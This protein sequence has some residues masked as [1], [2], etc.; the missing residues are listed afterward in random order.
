M[1]NNGKYDEMM[2][3]VVDALNHFYYASDVEFQKYAVTC[4]AGLC[5]H[6]PTDYVDAPVVEVIDAFT[7]VTDMEPEFQ[8][9]LCY[10]LAVLAPRVSN[11][12]DHSSSSRK[13]VPMQ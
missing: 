13:C 4:L 12:D 5:A 1:N 11:L 9:C 10:V 6:I 7:R 3:V 8:D 2:G